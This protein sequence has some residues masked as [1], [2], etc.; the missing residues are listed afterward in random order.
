MNKNYNIEYDLLI[1]KV[2]RWGEVIRFGG[3]L[4]I[5]DIEDDIK[6]CIELLR[7]DRE[8]IITKVFNKKNIADVSKLEIESVDIALLALVV[9][10]DLSI[11]E[12]DLLKLGIAALLKDLGMNK[13]PKEILNKDGALTDNQL[14]EIRKHPVFSVEILKELGFQEEITKIVIEHHE[15]WDGKGYPRGL[16]GENINYLSRIISV[17][18]GYNA[19]KESRPY[20]ESLHGYDAIKMIIGDNGHRYDPAILNVAV[21]SI[22]IYP[23]GS[24]VAL[25]DASICKVVGINKNKP[26]RPIVQV[27]IN[28][29]GSESKSNTI[30]DISDNNHFFIVR[31]VQV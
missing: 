14:A 17:V 26:L 15:R 19:I 7:N 16:S 3:T 25:N 18:D 6:N 13:V 21:K 10:L 29:N 27:I 31:S 22:G 2:H 5:E 4:L 24:Y 28:K 23:L 12:D 9:G 8:S 11:S 20:R 1:S 30:I